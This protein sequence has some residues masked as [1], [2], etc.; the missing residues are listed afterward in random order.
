MLTRKS[1]RGSLAAIAYPTSESLLGLNQPYPVEPRLER[2]R[3]PQATY[4][5]EAYCRV[6]ISAKALKAKALAM[7]K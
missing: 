1:C 4:D 5:P 3:L 7:Q 6:L 2:G